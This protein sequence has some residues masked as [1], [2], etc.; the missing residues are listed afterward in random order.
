MTREIRGRVTG[1]DG[2]RPLVASHSIHGDVLL[3][4]GEN[5]YLMAHGGEVKL[6][7]AMMGYV[8]RLAHDDV[9]LGQ[10][11]GPIL[12]ET[13]ITSEY[14]RDNFYR[15]LELPSRGIERGNRMRV[16]DIRDLRW[17]A[18]CWPISAVPG[19]SEVGGTGLYTTEST[20]FRGGLS[21][22]IA[23]AMEPSATIDQ[24]AEHATTLEHVDI[25]AVTTAM[26]RLALG[27]YRKNI[28]GV[29]WRR[30]PGYE[31]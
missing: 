14:P 31:E 2:P 15:S 11:F 7:A 12:N 25:P 16:A 21:L 18:L 28:A 22:V 4:I 20:R 30:L 9:S 1:V 29:F 6:F 3:D 10:M 26:C 8:T 27:E 5:R 19:S 24:V 13:D 17:F 23:R